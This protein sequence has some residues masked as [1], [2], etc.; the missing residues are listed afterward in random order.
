VELLA[1]TQDYELLQPIQAQVWLD[2][3][4]TDT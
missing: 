4:S 2:N 1:L 3:A